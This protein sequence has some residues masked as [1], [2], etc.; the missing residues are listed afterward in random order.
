MKCLIMNPNPINTDI[1]NIISNRRS[2]R[3]FLDK[4]VPDDVLE[5]I[6]NAGI[7]APF[8]AQLYSIIYTR[9]REKM[10]LKSGVYPSTSVFILFLLDFNKIE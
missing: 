3:K 9:N 8:A 6:L 4:D 7:R 10:R 1:F 5:D 2:I